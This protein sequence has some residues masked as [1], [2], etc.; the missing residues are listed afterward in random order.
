MEGAQAAVTKPRCVPPESFDTERLRLR[1]PTLADADD[2]FQYAS[3]PE[4]TR[5]LGFPTHRTRD[6]AAEF[7]R[8]LA[9]AGESGRRYGWAITLAGSDRLIGVV[10]IR[11]Q[12]SR[13]DVGYVLARAW[14]GNG[15][16]TEAVR[17]IVAWALAQEPIDRV[18]A[19]CDV[20]NRASARVLEKVGMKQ[21][22]VLRR[23]EVNPN[24]G[25]VAR[26]HYSY[27]IVRE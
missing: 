22:G 10:E 9:A 3:D 15:Y 14:W 2:V 5:H 6:T 25:P 12:G 4:V 16:M 27:S 17:P 7:L 11:I 13:A 23:W 18:W 1:P 21:E 8:A 20:E 24:I 19:T 26:D